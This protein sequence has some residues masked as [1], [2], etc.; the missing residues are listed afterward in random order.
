MKKATPI[1]K[2]LE[3][4]RQEAID[5][6]VA[7]AK[8]TIKR[9]YQQLDADGWDANATAAYPKATGSY[10][11]GQ[12]QIAKARYALYRELTTYESATGRINGPDYRRP[13]REARQRYLSQAA[14]AAADQ[15]DAYIVKLE[16]K[17]GKHTAAEL[18]GNFIWSYSH[19]TVTKADGTTEIWRTQMIVNYS[20]YGKAFNQ[21][22]TRKVKSK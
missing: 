2:A 8:E 17:A 9:V 13:C 22:P 21:F 12:Y 11:R 1:R 4:L 16:T 5:R 14:Q 15:Y 7:G 20:V 18:D 6:A 10:S 3:P 19:I